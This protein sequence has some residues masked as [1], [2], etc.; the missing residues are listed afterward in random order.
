MEHFR[1]YEM[2]PT[3]FYLVEKQQ[4]LTQRNTCASTVSTVYCIK[5]TMLVD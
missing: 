5:T 4:F 1:D 2:I 3:K